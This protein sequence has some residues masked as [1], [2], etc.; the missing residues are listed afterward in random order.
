MTS[1]DSGT[2]PSS[3]WQYWKVGAGLFCGPVGEGHLEGRRPHLRPLGPGSSGVCER[4][5]RQPRHCHD[6]R[7]HC[8]HLLSP[9]FCP[10]LHTRG[11][12]H[13]PGPC[14]RLA[15]LL[16]STMSFLSSILS[17]LVEPRSRVHAG[18]L[19]DPGAHVL[20]S[21]SPYLP[22]APATVSCLHP[23]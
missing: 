2:G 18:G 23:H 5:P 6:D 19:S 22:G 7:S 12:E 16:C 20:P 11:L 8:G 14:D 17:D 21:R 9:G 13:W 1:L 15:V 3:H 10:F 4:Q